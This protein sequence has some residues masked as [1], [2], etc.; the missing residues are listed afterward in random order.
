MEDLIK[1]LQIFAKYSK[2]KRP[3]TTMHNMLVVNCVSPRDVSLEDI[4]ELAKLGFYP[5]FMDD[6]DDTNY[7][8][9]F[10]YSNRF[11]RN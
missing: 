8:G 9:N 7:S 4:I 2:D 10:F 1:A 6:D 5:E 11:G 3:T